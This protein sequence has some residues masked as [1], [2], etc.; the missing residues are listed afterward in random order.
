MKEV[1]TFSVVKKYNILYTGILYALALILTSNDSTAQA[2]FQSDSIILLETDPRVDVLVN[3]YNKVHKIRGY[4]IQII[5]SSKRDKSK[6][7]LSKFASIYSEL[8]AHESYQQPFYT[9]KV[10]DFLTKLEAEKYHQIIKDQ[11]P[12]SFIIPDFVN[13]INQYTSRD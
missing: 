13:P 9:I 6:K 2:F 10:G 3:R 4:R 8:I 5:S 12:E 11:F 7:A 1:I